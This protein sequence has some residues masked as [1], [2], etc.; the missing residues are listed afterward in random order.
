MARISSTPSPL[1]LQFMNPVQPDAMFACA[2]AA[3]ANR[4][5]GYVF[6]ED[7]GTFSRRRVRRIEDDAEMKVPITDVA[8]QGRNQPAARHVG[9]CFLDAIDQRGDR[10]AC[11]GTDEPA[12]RL[13]REIGVGHV[14]AGF[15]Q[16]GSFLRPLG[17]CEAGSAVVGGDLFQCLDLLC[18]MAGS[19]WSARY[20]SSACLPRLC[21]L[22]ARLRRRRAYALGWPAGT[23][24]DLKASGSPYSWRSERCLRSNGDLRAAV[25]P[26]HAQEPPSQRMA[27]IR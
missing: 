8:N 18:L 25:R 21:S 10:H 23:T 5:H 26:H 11:I 24:G 17:P 6:G 13:Q 16:T 2:G 3:K 20:C 1:L 19:Q 12:T 27:G 4:A 7:F 22:C 15:P 14:M 9:P